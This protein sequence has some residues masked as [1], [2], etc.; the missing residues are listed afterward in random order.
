MKNNTA[1][2]VAL[3]YLCA[4]AS[5]AQDYKPQFEKF[6]LRNGLSVVLHRDTTLPLVSVNMTYHA[7]SAIDPE[8]RTGLANIAG[9]MLLIG[10]A[11]VPREELL[12]LRNE[13]R[14]SISALTT[15]DWVGIASIFPMNRLEAAIMIEADRMQHSAEAFSADQFGSMI[16]SLKKE[17]ARRGKQALG[18]LTQQV[19]HELYAEGHPY[20]HNSIGE[21]ID[22]DSIT[23]DE[24]REFSRR[25]HVPANAFL[26]VGGNFDPAKTRALIE[27]YFSGIPGGQ[28]AGWANIPE[29]FTPIGQGAFVVEDRIGFN[30]VHLIFPTVRAGHPDEPVLKLIAKALNGSQN[31]LLYT[32]LVNVNPLVHSVDVSQSSNELTGTFWITVTC[33]LETRLTTVYDQV[34]RILEAIAAEGVSDDELTAARNQSAMEFYTPLEAFYGFGGRCDVLNLGNMLGDSP[35]FSFTL[36]QNQQLATSASVRRAAGMYLGTG[37]QLVVS[38]VPIGKTDY[39]VTIQ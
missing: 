39:A 31:A 21:A 10:T 33:K 38:V 26:T 6:T 2:F 30:Q 15:V 14:V 22:V 18:T 37:N 36:Q 34:M 28:P 29:A 17:H 19:F 9:E 20:R 7:G 27:K 24:V 35:L 32:N 1:I 5:P 3:F 11:N 13:E 12:R 25:F 16:A 4:A 23:I 8:G